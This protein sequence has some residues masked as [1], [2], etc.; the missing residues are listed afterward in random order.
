[1]STPPSTHCWPPHP[2]MYSLETIPYGVTS[3]VVS[4][5]N[6]YCHIVLRGG[7]RPN[8]DPVSISQASEKLAKHPSLLQS[9]I[10]DCSH[11]NSGKDYRNQREVFNHVL[12]QRM[13]YT[14]GIQIK[15]NKAICGMMIESNVE[16]GKQGFVYGETKKRISI[17]LS[18]LPMPALAGRKP[19]IFC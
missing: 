19:K 4:K 2:P 18:P 14:G 7:K 16:E 15:S 6:R 11:K 10:V 17:P 13:G 3:R 9:L 1:M 5:G 12:I 8:Y